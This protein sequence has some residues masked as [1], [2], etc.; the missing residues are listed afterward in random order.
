[1]AV[2]S[3]PCSR[4]DDAKFFTEPH[5]DG[6]PAILV[7]LE[8]VSVADLKSVITEA[9][10]CLTPAELLRD[11]KMDGHGRRASKITKRSIATRR[12]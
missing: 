3:A 6:F 8:A 1:L 9:W 2:R 12:P 7:R 4:N 5:Y 10:R 11:A